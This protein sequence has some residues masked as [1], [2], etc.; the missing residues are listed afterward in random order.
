[1]KKFLIS[2]LFLNLFVVSVNRIQAQLTFTKLFEQAKKQSPEL[3]SLQASKDFLSLEAKLIKAENTS[4]KAFLSS[5]LLIAPYFNNNGHFISTNPA[6]SAI[7]YDI[8]ITNGGLYSVLLNA[9]MPL[10]NHKQVNNLL[11]QNGLEI[12]KINTQ[13][14][15]LSIEIKHT[16]ALQYLD[17][18]ASQVEYQSLQE[19]LKFIA[20]QLNM[21]EELTKHGLY[22][23]VDYRLLQTAYKA[24]S[25]NL[26]NSEASLQLKINQIKTTCG[27]EDTVTFELADFEPEFDTEKQDSSLFLQSYNE[28]SLS[29][30]VQQ[31]V[32]DNRYKP[33]VKVFANTGLNSTS[34]P[35]LG[36]HFGMSAG[37][38]LTYTLYDGK[39]KQINQQQQLVL[40]DQ[41]MHE[42]E[43]KKSE[44]Q[45]QKSAYISAI[46]SLNLS[47]SKEEKL[48][49]DYNEILTLYNQEL[50]T[51][52]VGIID[53]LNF[54]QQFNQNKLALQNHIIERNKLIVEYDYWNE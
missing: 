42:K 35:Y 3:V 49:N 50:Q 46:Q 40:V 15:T 45:K 47:I 29:A 26:T 38:Q 24:D 5:D 53:Y 39:Q 16:L 13:I 52:Q 51:A 7:G 21:V 30:K 11:V 54:L 4:P 2:F 32:F 23:Y 43:L 18:L 28:D 8:G 1:M 20:E 27:L 14:K 44:I 25:I 6:S 37:L 31:N 33:Q 17:A 22:R 9:E 19:N 12:S 41:A 36:N 34:I 48:Q 10:F